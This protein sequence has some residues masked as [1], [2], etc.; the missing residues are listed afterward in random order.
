ML[1]PTLGRGR[2]RGATGRA[3][4]ATDIRHDP[5][6]DA[7]DG[8]DVGRQIIG[9]NVANRD[10]QTEAH[11]E[12]WPGEQEDELAQTCQSPLAEMPGASEPSQ[13]VVERDLKADGIDR[14]AD[15]R[16]DA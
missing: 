14:I 13:R 4:P 10:K 3:R 9:R 15:D 8:E 12:Q 6:G 1:N 11:A 5:N 2:C 16:L 7:A